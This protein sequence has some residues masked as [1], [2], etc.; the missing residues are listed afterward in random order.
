MDEVER[1]HLEDAAAILH[2][3]IWGNTQTWRFI[4]ENDPDTA[5][6]IERWEAVDRERY[7]G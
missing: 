4:E 3:R 2:R 7:R 1:R 6:L 5:D